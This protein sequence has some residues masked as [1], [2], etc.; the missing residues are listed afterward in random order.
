MILV[1]GGHGNMGQRYCRILDKVGV[2]YWVYDVKSNC[3]PMSEMAKNSSA[4]IVATPTDTHAQLVLDLIPYKRP[5]LCEKPISLETEV[6]DGVV[7]VARDSGAN[8]QMVNQYSFMVPEKQRADRSEYNYF[9]HGPHGLYWDCINIVGLAKGIVTLSNDSPVWKCTIN[10]KKLALGDVDQAYVDMVVS[11]VS[12]PKPN[13]E[14]I[15]YAHHKVA[16]KIRS[17]GSV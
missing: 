6:V 11:W 5:I 13:I 12:V 1:I 4:F 17:E 9:K 2:R 10:G 8:L 14:Y 7:K 15:E 3:G 16:E